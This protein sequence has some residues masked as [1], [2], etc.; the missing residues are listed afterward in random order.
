MYRALWPLSAALSTVVALSSPC[1]QAAPH[2][3]A[4]VTAAVEDTGRPDQDKQ[5]DALR[6]PADTLAFAGVKP[7]ETVA[8]LIPGQGYYTRLLSKVVGSSGKVYTLAPP[9]RPNTPPGRDM[10]AAAKAIAENPAYSNVTVM[11]LSF[12]QNAPETGFGLP[13]QVDLVWTSDNYHDLHN[14]PNL[15]IAAFNKRV[16]EALKPGGTYFIL[17]HAAA[18]GTGVSATHTLHRIDP[19]AVKEEV[20]A[21]GFKYVGSSNALHNPADTHEARVFDASIQGHTDQFIFKFRKPK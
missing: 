13:D 17:D 16:F 19:A 12:G 18:A 8:E 10:M 14:I 3:P 9:P 2:I 21:A 6:K 7:G 5:R 11:P 20:E 4:Y 1:A 15:D